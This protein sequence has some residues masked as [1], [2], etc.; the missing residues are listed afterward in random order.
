MRYF[1]GLFFSTF[2]LSQVL[3]ND[4]FSDFRGSNETSLTHLWAFDDTSP[5][6]SPSTKDHKGT[7]DLNKLG[8]PP[9]L[10]NTFLLEGGRSKTFSAGNNFV[11]T[12]VS[13]LATSFTYSL[14]FRLSGGNPGI[15]MRII[16]SDN[17]SSQR[18]FWL[19]YHNTSQSFRAYV[20]IVSTLLFVQSTETGSTFWNNYFDG[21]WHNIMIT[22]DGTNQTMYLDGVL[23]GGPTAAVGSMNTH[24]QVT[25][26]GR[27]NSGVDF[28]GDLEQLAFYSVVLSSNERNNVM[29]LNPRWFIKG[30]G[31]IRKGSTYY[32]GFNNDTLYFPIPDNAAAD[33]V[34][35]YKDSAGAATT[36]RSG[37]LQGTTFTELG[38][39]SANTSFQSRQVLL[40]NTAFS[41]DSLAF[42]TTGEAFIEDILLQRQ[43][44]PVDC[45]Q[46]ILN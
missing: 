7:F 9:D 44:T 4:N 24:P 5:T 40:N 34:L 12:D 28:I 43:I 20:V 22:H 2:L 11:T 46:K 6:W 3:V 10:A 16:S 17:G 18:N 37:T 41:A 30:A 13:D 45:G 26:V 15:N 31:S 23:A 8:T 1:L 42:I 38:N 25:Y 21:A 35:T 29:N 32:Q 27:S 19:Q 36:L 14:W 33:F 39:F